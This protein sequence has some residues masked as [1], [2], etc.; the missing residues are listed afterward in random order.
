[1]SSLET[2]LP[3]YLQAPTVKDGET[4][5]FILR[6][7]VTDTPTHS[8]KVF[9]GFVVVRPIPDTYSII[10]GSP[11]SSV[12]PDSEYSTDIYVCDHGKIL[13]RGTQKKKL[14]IRVASDEFPTKIII[15]ET[16]RRFEK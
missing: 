7:D 1:M 13:V 5:R 12:K 6:D 2:E 3:A 10:I 4:R 14:E 11:D 8:V 9:K 16:E 15:D